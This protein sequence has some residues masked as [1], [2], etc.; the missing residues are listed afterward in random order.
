MKS[1]CPY[2][3]PN[4]GETYTFPLP[5][6]NGPYHVPEIPNWIKYAESLFFIV[7]KKMFYTFMPHTFKQS[8]ST[9]SG[10]RE[11]FLSSTSSPSYLISIT[12]GLTTGSSRLM[13]ISL[14]QIL[15]LRF[16][17]LSRYIIKNL[18][19]PIL[20]DIYFVTAYIR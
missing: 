16:S 13:P 10:L 18:A 11:T 3:I 17:K 2:G 4:I 20:W 19:N 8:P 1:F 7:S 12:L 15:L 14:L 6:L 9:N 5:P